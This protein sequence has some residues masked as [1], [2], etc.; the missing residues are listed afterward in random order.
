MHDN[1]PSHASLYTSEALTRFGRKEG[2]LMLRP[3][4]SH[5]LNPIEN[6]WSILKSIQRLQAI[7]IKELS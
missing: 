3:A 2:R 6:F 5:D 7:L 1:V 4:C